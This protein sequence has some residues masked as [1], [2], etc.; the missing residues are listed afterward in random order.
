MTDKFCSPI[1]DFQKEIRLPG[2]K[3]I[4][5]RSAIFNA[6]AKGSSKVTGYLCSEDCLS[7]LKSLMDM[8]V[9]VQGFGQENIEI[10]GCDFNLKEPSNMLNMNNSGTG[11]RLMCGVLAG[12]NMKATLTGDESLC[13]RP[14][15]RIATPLSLMGAS[16]SSDGEKLFPPLAVKGG[17][18]TGIEYDSP[19]ASAQVKSAV[20][21]AAIQADGPTVFTEPAVSRDHT[22]RMLEYFGV[23]FEKIGNKIT[24][25]GNQKF[26]AKDIAVP[27]DISSAAF[28]IVLTLLKDN[29]ELK[30][31]NVGLNPTRIGIIDVLKKMGAQIEI[32]PYGDESLSSEPAGDIVVK[33]SDLQGIVID[34][35]IIPN[36]IDEIPIIALAAAYAKG[37]TVIA[38]AAELRV[39][40]SDRISA[41]VSNF[42]SAGVDIEEKPDGFVIVGGNKIQHAVCETFHDHRIAMTMAVAGSIN[43]NGMTVKNTECIDTSFPGF[44]EKLE[45]LAN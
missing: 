19:I 8:G 23:S 43:E 37:E 40:E 5:H 10:K 44:F 11:F 31:L 17:A 2:D 24:I 39:K 1:G 22:E 25:D 41:V 32:Y 12:Q 27:G 14:M 18:L 45:L 7:T 38:D 6:L 21:L 42:K 29:S 4:S 26:T 36:V 33:S 16:F 15:D 3:S 30:I 28:F 35:E 9:E 13:K 34:G 20:L